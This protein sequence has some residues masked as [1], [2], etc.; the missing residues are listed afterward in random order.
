MQISL[1][2]LLP[3]VAGSLLALVT[4]ES[5]AE[6][7]DGLVTFDALLA[8]EE[9]ALTETGAEAVEAATEAVP[10]GDGG[11]EEESSG[12]VDTQVVLPAGPFV[13]DEGVDGPVSPMDTTPMVDETSVAAD[14]VE[15]VED[16]PAF[17]PAAQ[18][19]VSREDA[20]PGQPVS[21][22]SQN[23]AGLGQPVSLVSQ[24][25]AGLRQSV[26][27]A[28]QEGAQGSEAGSVVRI[29]L[30]GEAALSHEGQLGPSHSGALVEGAL[31]EKGGVAV[32]ESPVQSAGQ[33]PVL[34]EAGVAVGQPVLDAGPVSGLVSAAL[35]SPSDSPLRIGEGAAVTP[36]VPRVTLDNVS[37]VAVRSVRFLV[38][39]GGE[40]KVRIRLIP[41]HLGELHISITSSDG[42][43][44]VE[45]AA[46]VATV[47][48]ALEGQ[49]G[50]LRAQLGREGL[51][52]HSVTIS[53]HLNSGGNDGGLLSREMFR[54]DEGGDELALTRQFDLED[55]G[56]GGNLIQGGIT[57]S[58]GL[59]VL[60]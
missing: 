11:G 18:V 15:A 24:N 42:A 6:G 39:H 21:L 54:F 43:V 41:P 59:N 52:V 26:S 4:G 8:Q 55:V 29:P 14:P 27:L 48:D 38:T 33:A 51:D 7:S 60:V 1:F 22:A 44:R 19:L 36:E 23:N 5:A 3:K 20:G 58:G 12:E 30:E 31:A 34:P 10:G 49:V 56:G 47:R 50:A 35:L 45:L 53:S 46:A 37:E 40:E 32:F 16:A 13:A 2:D 28:S 17:N 9:L 25:S 57:G